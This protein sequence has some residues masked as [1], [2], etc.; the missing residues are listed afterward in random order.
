MK[1]LYRFIVPALVILIIF[2]VYRHRNDI[3]ISNYGIGVLA[4]KPLDVTIFVH[5]TVG[6]AMGLMNFAEVYND[7]I[8]GTGYSNLVKAMRE[9]P[10]F[11]KDQFITQRGLVKIEPSFDHVN[12]DNFFRAIYPL[13]EMYDIM[14]QRSGLGSTDRRYYAFGW[15]GL[16][17]QNKRRLDAIRLYNHLVDEVEKFT[18]EGYDPRITLLGYSHGGNILLLL[19]A[20]DALVRWGDDV[21]DA[22]HISEDQKETLKEMRSIM[23]Q[24][25]EKKRISLKIG[26]KAY[27]YTPCGQLP[28]VKQALLLGCPVQA[29]TDLFVA[30]PLFESVIFLYSE[31]DTVQGNDIFSTRKRASEQRVDQ[32]RFKEAETFFNQFSHE[33]VSLTHARVFRRDPGQ[34]EKGKRDGES[35]MWKMLQ[36]LLNF[37]EDDTQ[38]D[39]APNHRD[40]WFISW[41]KIDDVAEP[42]FK[43]F[44]VAVLAPYLMDACSKN[45]E[46]GDVDFITELKKEALSLRVIDR[47]NKKLLKESEILRPEI[48]SFI[49]KMKSLKPP[50]ATVHEEI[51]NI[52]KYLS[53]QKK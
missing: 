31:A 27:D 20:I 38:E 32:K 39:L 21:L 8:R 1:W 28:R 30:S 16:L 49:D 47:K 13:T 12:P 17:S 44:P 23:R 14:K 43:L 25:P 50:Y 5:G 11:L 9:D 24:L 48:Q 37:G 4:K 46:C 3:T 6:T 15:S 22:P 36:T 40:L 53:P 42:F 2:A 29:E 19:G 26:E 10:F 35:P 45:A 33:K 34:K 41:K 51:K 7:Q 18:R 52:S